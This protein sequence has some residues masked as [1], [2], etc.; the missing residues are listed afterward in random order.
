MI[1]NLINDQQFIELEKEYKFLT[2]ARG[3]DLASLPVVVV[4]VE[5]TGLDYSQHELIEIG[6]LKLQGREIVGVFNSLIKPKSTI[7]PEITR[8]TGIDNEMV[9][10]FPAAE[11]ILAKFIDFAGP[12]VLIAH[13]VDFDIPFLKHHLQHLLKKE[14]T[15]ESLCTLKL[16]RYLLPNLVN[17]K[18]HTIA[19]HFNIP[20]A[21]R[22]RAMG[23]VELTYQVWLQ[24][25]EVLQ[26][27]G[28]TRK[29][30]L[31]SLISRL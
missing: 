14:L 16:S 12:S 6:A 9:K 7:T 10:D 2:R 30:D 24:F 28:I 5:S 1:H 17:H 27:K 23:D 26:G 22:H 21:N 8:L 19:S 20:V 11:Q 3:E 25:I 15:N 13:N 29:V 4:D 31:D 18:L